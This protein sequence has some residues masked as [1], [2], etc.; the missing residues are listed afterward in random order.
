MHL[1]GKIELDTGHFSD[2]GPKPRNEDSLAVRIPDAARLP[3][4]GIVAC[5]ADGV[6]AANAG[7]EAAEASV[8]GFTSD[9]YE[10]PESWQV[11]TAGQRVLTALNR[12]LYAHGQGFGTA[13]KG[14]VTTF[15]ALVLKSRTAHV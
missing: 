6:S 15:I 10:T 2:A 1:S 13:E 7:K 8:L 5:I 4:K 9:Y 11:K 14:C 12:W 3:T